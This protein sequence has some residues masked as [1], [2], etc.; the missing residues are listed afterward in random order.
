MLS[1]AKARL[2]RGK[3]RALEASPFLG[4]IE[5]ELVRHQQAQPMRR[6]PED[7]QLSLF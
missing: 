1:R 4:D 6:K 2:W 3:V 7:K 5:N